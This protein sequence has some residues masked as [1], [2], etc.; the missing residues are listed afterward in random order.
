MQAGPYENLKDLALKIL[1]NQ[2][3]TVPVIHSNSEDG[4]YPQLLH[5]ASLSG[6]LKC[7]LFIVPFK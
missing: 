3:A 4:S 2:V 7:K 6:M 5:L 1:Q